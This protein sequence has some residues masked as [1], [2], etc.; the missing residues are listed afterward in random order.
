MAYH[1]FMGKQHIWTAH[2]ALLCPASSYLSG[3]VEHCEFSLPL[4]GPAIPTGLSSC[5]LELLLTKSSTSRGFSPSYLLYV[6]LTQSLDLSS[7]A[8]S[9]MK[10]ALFLLAGSNLLALPFS[11]KMQFYF[12]CVSIYY[13]IFIGL[14]YYVL[15]SAVCI[16]C[17]FDK[18]RNRIWF[19]NHYMFTA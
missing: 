1:W 16:G 15:M 8:T 18:H 5:A 10:F 13:F 14:I 11:T 17:K 2:R 6:S 3:L 4:P 19:P 7:V 9:S 12:M